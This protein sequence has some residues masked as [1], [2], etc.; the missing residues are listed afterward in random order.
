MGDG[1]IIS[2]A[3]VAHYVDRKRWAWALSPIWICMPVMTSGSS[4]P[5]PASP[6]RAD[7][8]MMRR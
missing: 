2:N 7:A 1:V 3:A 6:R 5:T 8:D 4:R